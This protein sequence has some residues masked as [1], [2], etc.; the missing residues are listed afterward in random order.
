MMNKKS[1]KAQEKENASLQSSKHSFTPFTN[2]RK[3]FK[4]LKQRREP[5]AHSVDSILDK[6]NSKNVN[7]NDKNIPGKNDNSQNLLRRIASGRKFRRKN[8]QS[9]ITSVEEIRRFNVVEWS[10]CESLSDNF[11]KKVQ[12]H[13]SLRRSKASLLMPISG[14]LHDYKKLSPPSTKITRYSSMN[15]INVENNVKIGNKWFSSQ[16]NV[17]ALVSGNNNDV[18]YFNKSTSQ[19]NNSTICEKR[20]RTK[21]R[22]HASL[23]L[24]NI[25]EDNLNER[26]GEIKVD[27]V[28]SSNDQERY[29]ESVSENKPTHRFSTDN[30][31]AAGSRQ[32]FKRCSLIVLT[33]HQK[34]L[35]YGSSPV[36][37]RPPIPSAPKPTTRRDRA[38]RKSVSTEA[39]SPRKRRADCSSKFN[40]RTMSDNNF[41]DKLDTSKGDLNDVSFSSMQKKS[42]VIVPES[43]PELVP[44]KEQ[45]EIPRTRSPQHKKPFSLCQSMNDLP[46]FILKNENIWKR[47]VASCVSFISYFSYFMYSFCVYILLHFV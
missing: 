26:T 31:F 2:L 32:N 13:N 30:I 24:P 44:E 35:L 1:K 33:D 23:S 16:Q 28:D 11:E 45:E 42:E 38:L 41:Q 8:V 29:Y 46:S 22:K 5:R 14:N 12:K 15:S 4:R 25:C 39:I 10:S 6:E 43:V 3:S 36:F 7:K 17:S 40:Q 27:E 9:M 47:S 37:D 19:K 34:N 21:G 18:N 20:K